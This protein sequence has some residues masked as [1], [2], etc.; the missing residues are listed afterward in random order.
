[1]QITPWD[2]PHHTVDKIVC[3]PTNEAKSYSNTE[4]NEK[5]PNISSSNS[6][7]TTL[8]SLVTCIGTIYACSMSWF[9]EKHQ[10]S[11]E[12]LISLCLSLSRKTTF[13]QSQSKCRRKCYCIIWIQYNKN[14]SKVKITSTESDFFFSQ[15]L[16]FT[17]G[18]GASNALK[19]IKYQSATITKY[20]HK[21]HTH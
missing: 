15:R 16:L 6:N 4:A 19:I 21:T 7:V 18:Y 13:F 20:S 5:E 2:L 9:S 1:M 8:G 3:T 12:K 10:S 17:F 14:L 11:S